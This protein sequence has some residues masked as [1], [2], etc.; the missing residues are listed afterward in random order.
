MTRSWEDH[1]NERGLKFTV[2]GGAAV[3][4]AARPAAKRSPK[5]P[6]VAPRNLPI[7]MEMTLDLP[8][9]P[10]ANH[11]WANVAGVGRVRS[12]R[13]R[14]WH[15]QACEEARLFGSGRI[16]GK[17]SICIEL[18]KLPARSDLDNRVK[19]TLDLLAGLITDDD[20][21]CVEQSAV[22]AIGVV[23]P[24]RMRVTVKRAA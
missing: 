19:P 20:S 4:E 2:Q 8:A 23:Q 14:R 5:P 18:G 22:W 7:V 17:F 21:N 16:A 11:C 6:I 15:K 1:L 12:S 13:Y 9:P 10:S 3:A 24:G